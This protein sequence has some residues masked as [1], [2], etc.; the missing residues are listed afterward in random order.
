MQC[1]AVRFVW[2]QLECLA[3]CVVL[4]SLLVCAIVQKQKQ[5]GYTLAKG[6]GANRRKPPLALLRRGAGD[7]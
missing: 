5:K 2:V 3:C 6:K 7:S 1:L 4:S